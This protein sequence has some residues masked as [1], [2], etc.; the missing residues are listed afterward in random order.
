MKMQRFLSFCLYLFIFCNSFGL[1]SNPQIISCTGHDACKNNVWNGEYD[2][3]CGAS[4]SE[5]TCKSTTL[6]C[7]TNGD[8]TI[9][10][11]GSGHDAYQYSTVNAKQ[12]NSFKLT[13]CFLSG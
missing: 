10:T 9:K 13:A 6:N 2:I 7:A 8:C 4:N 3:R 1:S 5:R 12:S 11:Q